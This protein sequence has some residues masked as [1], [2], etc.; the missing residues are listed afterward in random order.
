MKLR[1]LLFEL[2]DT[3][4]RVPNF[5]EEVARFLI[6]ELRL[7]VDPK[8]LAK[9]FRDEWSSKYSELIGKG[10]YR[11]VRQLSRETVMS[12]S[13]RYSLSL[14]PQELDYF[15]SAISSM[16]IELSELYDDVIETIDLLSREGFGIYAL[17][18]LDNDIA[19][20]ILLKFNAL[21]YFKGVVSSDLTGVGKP[22]ARIFQAALS[23]AKVSRDQALI[24]SGLVEDVIGSKLVGIKVVYVNRQNKRLE[25][26]PDYVI[27]SLRELPQLIS[28][29]S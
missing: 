14:S 11:S 15:G 9:R 3:L 13:R 10:V 1:A 26:E 22:A 20:K 12:I 27:N 8:E 29:L 19:K 17:T 5:D 2:M 23:R 21:R 16:I 25:I 28:R 4:V 24:V 6:S 18:N 7:K